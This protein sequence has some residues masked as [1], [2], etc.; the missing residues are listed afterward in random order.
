MATP[1]RFLSMQIQGPSYYCINV[2]NIPY[3]RSAYLATMVSEVLDARGTWEK[4]VLLISSV[5]A[6]FHDDLLLFGLVHCN[7]SVISSGSSVDRTSINYRS[8]GKFQVQN[9][10]LE[11]TNGDKGRK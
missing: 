2:P 7:L 8:S 9:L 6:W 5:H 3:S 1:L 11:A 10:P 4:M